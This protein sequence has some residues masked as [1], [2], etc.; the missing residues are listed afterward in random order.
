ML[1]LTLILIILQEKAHDY[2]RYSISFR[3]KDSVFKGH[4]FRKC[5]IHNEFPLDSIS[6]HT[7]TEYRS[8]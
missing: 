1:Y 4:I 5:L 8:G 7:A 3:E 6:A 2:E